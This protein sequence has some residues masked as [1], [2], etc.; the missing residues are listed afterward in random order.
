M[1][2]IQVRQKTFDRLSSLRGETPD[3]DRRYESYDSVIERLL[4][5]ETI[6][7]NV[8]GDSDE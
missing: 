1:P 6:A 5:K 3:K 7:A 4:P 2:T 8:V